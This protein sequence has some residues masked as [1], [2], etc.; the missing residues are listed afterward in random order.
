MQ[1]TEYDKARF[2]SHVKVKQQQMDYDGGGSCWE[3]TGSKH[4]ADSRGQFVLNGRREYAPRVAYTIFKGEIP[5]GLYVCHTCDNPNCVNPRH[6]FAGTTQQ[7]QEDCAMKGRKASK[8]TPDIVRAIRK[9][10]IPHDKSFGFSALGRKYNVN[11]GAVFN[12]YY[13]YRW[14]WVK[15][16]DAA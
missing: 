11:P 7:N 12:A 5:E 16:E 10:C 6:L 13:G 9:E 1:I 3:W 2:W 14:T 15:D 8:M 4:P